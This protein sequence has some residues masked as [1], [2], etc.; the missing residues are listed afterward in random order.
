MIDLAAAYATLANNGVYQLPISILKVTTADGRVL[1]DNQATPGENHVDPRYSYLVTNILSDNRARQQLFG[2]GNLLELGNR[3]AAVKTGTTDDNRDAWTV[4]YTPQ[5]VTA[6]WVGNFNNS[7]MH[8]VMGATGATPIWHYYM[9]RVLAN[10][11]VAQF[12]RPAG[13]VEKP[14]T[15]SGQLSCSSATTFRVEL[16]VA[17]TEPQGP[18]YPFRVP[19]GELEPRRGVAGEQI[20]RE[21]RNGRQIQ[22]R[23]QNNGRTTWE[24]VN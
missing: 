8:G 23:H 2:P 19:E 21:V 6:V 3:P 4:G 13:L 18:C 15:K 22:I 17:G 1:Q 7:P 24:Y 5:L 10:M 20:W 9:E 12:N 16:F 11:P 14:I